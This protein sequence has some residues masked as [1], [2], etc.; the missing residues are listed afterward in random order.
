MWQNIAKNAELNTEFAFRQVEAPPPPPIWNY[1]LPQKNIASQILKTFFNFSLRSQ[2]NSDYFTMT[3][4]CNTLMYTSDFIIK[5]LAFCSS[6]VPQVT[7]CWWARED[8]SVTN[9]HR[10]W[11]F[12]N[13]PFSIN[14]S[15]S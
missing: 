10:G 5:Q 11:Q 7:Q 1:I 4:Q 14:Y 8:E 6:V 9:C 13:I 12:T 3:S 15:T 2:P